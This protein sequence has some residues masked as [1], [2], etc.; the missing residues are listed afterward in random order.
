MNKG[1][2]SEVNQIYKEKLATISK[3]ISHSGILTTEDDYQLVKSSSHGVV[4]SALVDANTIIYK[5]RYQGTTSTIENGLLEA[6]CVVIENKPIQECSD[7]AGIHLEC[8]LR[9]DSQPHPIRGIISPEN[10]DPMFELPIKLIRG[11]LADYRTKTGY[12]NIENFYDK[13]IS[14]TWRRLSKT[15]RKEQIQTAI[16]TS[17]WADGVTVLRL[18]TPRRVILG[19][20]NDDLSSQAKQERM[21]QLEKHLKEQVE[22]TLQLY[23]Q[24]KVDQNKLRLQKGVVLE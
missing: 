2:L 9:T 15:E 17:T 23:M 10:A 1:K 20:E 24:P 22:S 18:E 21:I 5:A 11:L 8:M 13:P 14:N 12:Q 7:H 16:D 3:S 6:L 4:L 19:F